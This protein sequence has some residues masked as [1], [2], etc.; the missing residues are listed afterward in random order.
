M[1]GKTQTLA[2]GKRIFIKVFFNAWPRIGLDKITVQ[3]ISG[4]DTK[5][6]L[7]MFLPVPEYEESRKSFTLDDE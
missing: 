7:K 4:L 5:F 1:V 6:L 3:E 2:A